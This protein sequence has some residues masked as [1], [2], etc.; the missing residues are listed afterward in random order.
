MMIPEL[1]AR[2]THLK[3]DP[4]EH[5]LLVQRGQEIEEWDALLAVAQ[6]H[7]MG[8]LLYWHMRGARVPLPQEVL[9]TLSGTFVRHRHAN[10]V[11]TR[12]LGQVLEAFA[13]V[14]IEAVVVKGGALSHLLYPEPTLRPM[15]DVDL[16][17]GR[18]ELLRAR[19]TLVELG[20]SAPLPPGGESDKSL[21][22]AGTIVEGVWVGIELHDD[23]FES[24]FDARLTLDDL[25]LP[26][27]SFSLGDSGAVA[28][29]LGLE[30][31]LWH[32]CEHL[33]FHTT[34]FL[35]WRLIWVTDILGV[36]ERFAAELDWD[37]IAREYPRVLSTLSLLQHLRPLRPEVLER[38]PA[39]AGQRPRGVGA[40]F[41]GWP[42]YSLSQQRGKSVVRIVKDTWL[43]PEWWL[44]LHRGLD[45]DALLW[46]ERWIGHPWEILGWMR[47]YWRNRTENRAATA[48]IE[49]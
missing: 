18:Q 15:S 20:M 49:A 47:H 13:A 7:G 3:P 21:P 24:A 6:R 44:R 22:T 29:T 37:R 35:P 17:I 34:V 1:L 36:A 43:P 42:R 40:D 31:L 46:R 4:S 41:A 9:Y 39:S 2:C 25:T 12:V 33:R 38:I 5:P 48:P 19:Q 8:P 23:L 10:Q 32:L 16:L 27:L 45:S 26:P 14:G 30:E 11:R 28:H